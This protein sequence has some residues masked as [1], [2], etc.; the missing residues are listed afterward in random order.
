MIEVKSRFL[1][2]NDLGQ[3]HVTSFTPE[4]AATDEQALLFCS[5]KGRITTIDSFGFAHKVA[6][7]LGQP[8][9]FIERPA[10]GFSTVPEDKT[11]RE[12]LKRHG[13][14]AVAGA[15]LET[16]YENLPGMD[17]ARYRV[18]GFS[19]GG[20]AAALA[21][22]AAGDRVM[23]HDGFDEPALIDTSSLLG[24]GR[25]IT[26]TGL[27]ELATRAS[28]A[29]STKRLFAKY[30]P[31]F[32][33]FLKEAK[34]NNAK[35]PS[36]EAE[37]IERNEVLRTTKARG[38]RSIERAMHRAAEDERP[39]ELRL[40][41]SGARVVTD[42][43]VIRSVNESIDRFD[44]KYGNNSTVKYGFVWGGPMGRWHHMA[45]RPDAVDALLGQPIDSLQKRISRSI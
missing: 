41:F 40:G 2:S 35:K 10:T 20:A 15:I 22:E 11:L 42:H 26:Y 27:A 44:S 45:S 6:E 29:P 25:F 37:T 4:D 30:D 39:F 17:T 14:V 3:L 8:T 23:A 31:A 21:L 13:F 36:K 7:T 12:D 5:L 16:L 43:Q 24:S 34:L 18:G 32:Q 1:E 33:N 19:A 28:V 38:L 9:H